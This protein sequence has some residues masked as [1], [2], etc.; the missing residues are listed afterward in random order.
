MRALTPLLFSCVTSRPVSRFIRQTERPQLPDQQR[1]LTDLVNA[2][3]IEREMV[4]AR[5]DLLVR[6]FVGPRRVGGTRAAGRDTEI[7]AVALVG[8]VSLLV[9]PLEERHVDVLARDVVDRRVA[10]FA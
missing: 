7:R 10:R 3:R 6:R 1:W 5:G 2:V 9:G 8:A 4:L